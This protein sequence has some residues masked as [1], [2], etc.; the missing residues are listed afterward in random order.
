MSFSRSSYLFFFILIWNTSLQAQQ[1]IVGKVVVQNSQTYTGKTE[2]LTNFPIEI[3]G[4]QTITDL[5]G[6]FQI[7]LSGKES[8]QFL[9]S[10]S[11]D[12]ILLN[13]MQLES[14]LLNVRDSLTLTIVMG[15]TQTVSANKSRFFQQLKKTFTK[16]QTRLQAFLKKEQMDSISSFFLENVFNTQINKQ[17]LENYLLDTEQQLEYWSNKLSTVHLDQENEIFK[18]AYSLLRRGNFIGL[19]KVLS[20]N[21]PDEED[22]EAWFNLRLSWYIANGQLQKM[23]DLY[24]L[25]LEIDYNNFNRLLEYQRFLKLVKDSSKSKLVEQRLL[26]MAKK[27]IEKMEVYH[28]LGGIYLQEKD[29]SRAIQLYEQTLSLLPKANSNYR[30]K[31]IQALVLQE[32]ALV[33]HI[34]SSNQKDYQYL[35]DAITI[36]EDLTTYQRSVYE[37]ALMRAE[38]LLATFYTDDREYRIALRTI[39]SSYLV[40]QQLAQQYPQLYLEELAQMS[41]LKG[42]LAAKLDQY[43]TAETSFSLAITYYERMAKQNPSLL[44]ASIEGYIQLSDLY[45]KQFEQTENID[46]QQKGIE[47]IDKAKENLQRLSIF[48]NELDSLW[49]TIEYYNGVLR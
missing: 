43:A 42:F 25:I 39:N 23:I 27:P 21:P 36:Y 9:T 33:Y 8:F 1:S 14:I 12:Y 4:I 24:D 31:P 37:V 30:F 6:L 28:T 5:N 16:T 22:S 41:M 3:S 48:Q 10:S 15:R 29:Y 34:Q 7:D 44:Y 19:E 26:G 17:L 18:E 40:A 13:Q 38:H 47:A 2:V 35:S 49:S 11:S 46:F 45:T 20:Q 32:L